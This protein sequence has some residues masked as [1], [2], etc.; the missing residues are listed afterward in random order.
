MQVSSSA[1]AGFINP[2][3]TP[4]APALP[5][6]TE[7][8]STLDGWQH[9]SPAQ[10]RPLSAEPQ[11]MRTMPLRLDDQPQPGL[12]RLVDEPPNPLRQP[13]IAIKPHAT[14]VDAPAS[15]SDA[16]VP[17]SSSR[18]LMSEFVTSSLSPGIAAQIAAGGGRG[19][20]AGAMLG[21]AQ[22]TEDGSVS[23]AF[24]PGKDGRP[25]EV[26]GQLTAAALAAAEVAAS[27]PVAPAAPKADPTEIAALEL[28]L[29]DPANQELIQ[30][31]G[32]EL[33]PLPTWTSVGKGIEARYGAD[34]GGRLYQLQLAQRA[35]EGEFLQAMDQALK[36]GPPS[37][38]SSASQ[39]EGDAANE[40]PGWTY[41]L[42]PGIADEHWH[43]DPG[44]FARQYVQGDTPAQ[45]AFVSLHGTDPVQF[46][47]ASNSEAGD[48]NRWE[49]AGI[50]LRLGLTPDA[51]V[52]KDGWAPSRLLRGEHHLDP[53]RITKLNN[54]EF[55]WF[56]PVHGFSTDPDNVKGDWLDRAFPVVFAGAMSVMTMGAASAAMGVASTS[57]LTAGQGAVLGAVGSA[58]NQ[59]VSGG[60][61]DFKQMLLA[62]VS[63]GATAGLMNVTGFG[64][65]M[66]SDVL[67]TRL[68]GHAGRAGV[69]GLVQQATG[70]K[71][72][73]G[74]VNSALASAAGEVTRH[75]DT[76][77]NEMKGLSPSEASALRL[78]SRATGSAMRLAGGGDPAAG[79]ASD[80]LNGLLG[81]QVRQETDRHV[82]A[83]GPAPTDPLGQLVDASQGRWDATGPAVPSSVTVARGDTLERIARQHY[84][85][86]WRAG[87]TLLMADN[88][89]GV[90]RWGSP[91]IRAGDALTI[92][93]LQGFN[94]QQ[95][96][97]LSRMGGQILAN[98]TQ[99]LNVRTQI[100][101]MRA[102]QRLVQQAVVAPRTPGTMTP[103]EAHALY[104]STGGRS[105]SYARVMGETYQPTWHHGGE[106]TG[107][108][109][110]HE[111]SWGQ[112]MNAEAASWSRVIDRLDDAAVADGG[113]L[114]T[115]GAAL[116]RAP[117]RSFL[118]FVQ[119]A[120]GAA[121]LAD[122]VVNTQLYEGL[123]GI[124]ADPGVIPA[125]VGRYYETHT[126][127]E[128]AAD[129]YVGAS[130]A[131][132][133]GGAGSSALGRLNTVVRPN[134]PVWV[135]GPDAPNRMGQSGAIN[136]NGYWIDTVTEA[137]RLAF[138]DN[139][140]LDPFTNRIA[141]APSNRPIQVD[142]I[143]PV[144]EIVKLPGF[145]DLTR[146]QMGAILQDRI[147]IG[148]LQPLPSHLNASK[149][150][151]VGG[152]WSTYRGWVLSQDY[153][154][155]IDYLQRS[156]RDRI[157][158]HIELLRQ[159]DKAGGK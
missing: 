53:D 152:D 25:L 49:V 111:S 78:L 102:Q 158:R 153:I 58:T 71:F 13:A 119:G 100:E 77:I 74:F 139:G 63:G 117:A 19:S 51:V 35:V 33:K 56:D 30:Q 126:I 135:W 37:P 27:A 12:Q 94:D 42:S 47:P 96:G 109:A 123:R 151:R 113:G 104:M 29:A 124:L 83:Q 133:G 79:L 18:L 159:A 67:S 143:F 127:G 137:Q 44:A 110:S 98:N 66:R 10:P 148:N 62:A 154:D 1:G 26:G 125:A 144:S 57:T 43:F 150:P 41:G 86:N 70:G 36:D 23:Q 156:V 55:V 97:Q 48:S 85:E 122:P 45:R 91:I 3:F 65:M 34:L 22:W 131:L 130:G 20:A 145:R 134:K 81:E 52:A 32:G 146:E 128:I 88:Q 101:A 5:V 68:M 95:L 64:N 87:M 112:R 69:Q 9:A 129:A 76:Q 11:Q 73:D 114:I 24:P 141:A 80:F 39:K 82:N 115:A 14:I 72:I 136:L 99:G 103:D 4:A 46:I 15:R 155:N 54:K 38:W 93:S 60:R 132:M 59:L 106:A 121:S 157:L 92:P 116:A 84:G 138:R 142:H 40:R 6:A 7:P 50:T 107:R 149:G 21:N 90:N 17:A 89:V 105:G 8:A 2:E 31:F 120:V 118:G 140:Y 16:P 28:L 61:L 108:T 75:L 147:G